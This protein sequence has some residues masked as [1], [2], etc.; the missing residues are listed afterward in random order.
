M[1]ETIQY[2]CE[3][4]GASFDSKEECLECEHSHIMPKK[5][6]SCSFNPYSYTPKA[7]GFMKNDIDCTYPMI[8]TVEMQDEKV[9]KYELK[10][11]QKKPDPLSEVLNNSFNETINRAFKNNPNRR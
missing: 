7:F 3:K 1:K 4:C 9:L 5:M 11:V 10:D 2:T 6:K 8:I